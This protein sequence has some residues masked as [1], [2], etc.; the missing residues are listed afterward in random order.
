M[1]EI[2]DCLEAWSENIVLEDWVFFRFVAPVRRVSKVHTAHIFKG[3]GVP[4]F[5]S[6][7]RIQQLCYNTADQIFNTNPWKPKTSQNY[8]CTVQ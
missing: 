6:N 3:Q 5:Q 2:G 4:I 7:I 1:S 8:S